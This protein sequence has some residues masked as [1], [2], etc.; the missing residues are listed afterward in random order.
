MNDAR[1]IFAIF[2]STDNDAID[3]KVCEKYPA[4]DR[5]QLASGQWLISSTKTTASAVYENLATKDT[6]VN[7][8]ISPILGYYG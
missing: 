5:R 7:C 1:K 6:N 4:T 8:I 3:L 2:G